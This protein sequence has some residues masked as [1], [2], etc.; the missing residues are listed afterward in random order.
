MD[1]PDI[2]SVI[3]EIVNRPGWFGDNRLTLMV[4]PDVYLALPDPATG[5]P[6]TVQEIEFEAGPGDDS[7][8]LMIEFVVPGPPPPTPT[9]DPLA[10]AQ[11]WRKYSSLPSHPLDAV[12]SMLNLNQPVVK[13]ISST[14]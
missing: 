1:T 10:P 12:M 8:T 3:Q 7:A 9:P 4:Y 14:R 6:T 13:E 2:T 11:N 5:S